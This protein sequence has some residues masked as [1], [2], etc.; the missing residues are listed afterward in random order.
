MSE[1]KTTETNWLDTVK[2]QVEGVQFGVVQITIHH[3]D[4]VQIERT[5]K[6]RID[7]TRT[8]TK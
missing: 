3:G 7:Q 6:I 4:V 2:K 5:E 8:Q 1:K